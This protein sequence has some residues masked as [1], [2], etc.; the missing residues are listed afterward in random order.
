MPVFKVLDF[1]KSLTFYLDV[2]GFV[3]AWRTRDDYGETAMLELGS[4]SLMLSTGTHLGAGEP[5]FTGTIYFE[6]SGVADDWESVRSRAEIVWPLEAMDYGTLEFGIRD[7]AGY[8]LAFSE[9]RG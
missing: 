8:T 5:T 2:L 9:D 1:E 6:T 4:G 3:L 7:P